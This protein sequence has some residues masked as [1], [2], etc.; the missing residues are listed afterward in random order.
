MSRAEP[1]PRCLCGQTIYPFLAQL[2]KEAGSVEPVPND[3]MRVEQA[4]CLPG[5]TSYPDQLR[6][7]SSQLDTVA[8]KVDD[9]VYR[10]LVSGAAEMAFEGAALPNGAKVRARGGQGAL[11]FEKTGSVA[12]WEAMGAA[13]QNSARWDSPAS[14]KE[15]TLS[16]EK[17]RKEYFKQQCAVHYVQVRA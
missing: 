12:C 11:Q 2:T 14:K 13:K 15:A 16:E 7:G 1:Y 5:E 9:T 8:Q 10:R 6:K 4:K 17:R 3:V